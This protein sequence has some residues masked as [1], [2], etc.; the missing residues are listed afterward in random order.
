MCVCHLKQISGGGLKKELESIIPHLEA[1]KKKINERKAQFADVLKQINRISNELSGTV[2]ENPNKIAIAENDL[3]QKKLDDL[4]SELLRLQ[5]E[6][7]FDVQF[8]F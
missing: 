4:R 2:E 8:A 1:V 7:V 3:S 6:K 5:K